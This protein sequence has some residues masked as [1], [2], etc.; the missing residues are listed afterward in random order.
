MRNGLPVCLAWWALMAW[1][2]LPQSALAAT[3]PVAL[4]PLTVRVLPGT[5][6][7]ILHDLEHVRMPKGAE[8]VAL[9]LDLAHKRILDG[10]GRVVAGPDT[11]PTPYLQSIVDKWRYVASL[12]DLATAHP[13]ELLSDWAERPQGQ[14]PLPWVGG[15]SA[16]FWV[17]HVTPPRQ[18]LVFGIGPIGDLCSL[19]A[20]AAPPVPGAADTMVIQARAVPPFGTEHIVVVTAADPQHVGELRAWLEESGPCHGLVDTAGELLKQIAALKDVRVGVVAS[21]SCRAAADC[22]K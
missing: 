4:P 22:P 14:P 7:A 3:T 21:H 18:L 17:P 12:R 15:T 6:P 10:A 9:Q 2:C 16:S 11:A 1:A 5:D 13:Q 19:G 8:P 20:R